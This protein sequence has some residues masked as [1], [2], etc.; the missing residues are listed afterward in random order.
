MTNKLCSVLHWERLFSLNPDRYQV[1]LRKP[2]QPV[3]TYRFRARK[4]DEERRN[5]KYVDGKVEEYTSIERGWTPH[6]Q[7]L[8][9]DRDDLYPA[10]VG[11]CGHLCF[12]G[13][14]A[15]GWFVRE[16]LK[17][18]YYRLDL[19]RIDLERTTEM[20]EVISMEAEVRKAVADETSNHDVA[21][22]HEETELYTPTPDFVHTMFGSDVKTSSLEK[23]RIPREW[24]E[25]HARQGSKHDLR[26]GH[27]QKHATREPASRL[28]AAAADASG[29]G[30]Q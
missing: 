24:R 10:V 20:E 28:D 8:A 11:V 27:D 9:V 17:Q 4:E 2:K 25:Q 21:T 26:A 5:F 1:Q 6:D 23:S 22:Q 16:P 7:S 19:H 12:I 14:L 18:L 15:F 3:L 29:E 13:F 30:T